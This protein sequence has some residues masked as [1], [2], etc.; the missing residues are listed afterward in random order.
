MV[1]QA[2]QACRSP[3]MQGCP[4]DETGMMPVLR[5]VALTIVFAL[6]SGS[7]L[8]TTALRTAH[9]TTEFRPAHGFTR[10]FRGVP[11]DPECGIANVEGMT[12][13]ITQASSLT[14]R[15][16]FPACSFPEQARM[17]VRRDRQDACVT[18]RRAHHSVRCPQR[19][20]GKSNARGQRTLQRQ[21]TM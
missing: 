18:C 15:V 19:M 6:P 5:V 12:K 17:P 10:I 14:G 4:F 1:V 9:A 13:S 3:N 8:G 20:V 16:G 11:E 21:L 7:G 2:S